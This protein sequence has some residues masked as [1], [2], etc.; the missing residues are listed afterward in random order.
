MKKQTLELTSQADMSTVAMVIFLGVFAVVVLATLRRS[1]KDFYDE[2]GR[3][4]FKGD[5]S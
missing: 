3:L 5:E 1:S 4:P 2:L